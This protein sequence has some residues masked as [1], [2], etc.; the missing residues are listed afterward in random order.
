MSA[1]HHIL[2]VTWLFVVTKY[3]RLFRQD[4]VLASYLWYDSLVQLPWCQGR[5]P[6]PFSVLVIF[7]SIGVCNVKL[8]GFNQ[9][10]R[11]DTAFQTNKFPP[12]HSPLAFSF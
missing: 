9:R 1:W 11:L 7:L 3:K 4:P 8:E 6:K 5:L 2:D 10:T 12:I